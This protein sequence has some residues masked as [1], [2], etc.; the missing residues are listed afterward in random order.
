[1]T[2]NGK[3]YR[4][5]GWRTAIWVVGSLI[6][7]L[8]FLAFMLFYTIDKYDLKADKTEV[9]AVEVRSV[10]RD[11]ILKEELLRRA[12][13]NYQAIQDLLKNQLETN[14]LLGQVLGVHGAR[15]DGRR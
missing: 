13:T 12:D 3:E 15:I 14:R 9:A 1:M 8:S 4:R 2:E 7:L 10:E 11:R 5:N 6:P